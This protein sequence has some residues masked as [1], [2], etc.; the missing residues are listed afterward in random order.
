MKKRRF[1]QLVQTY[2]DLIYNYAFYFLHNRDEAEDVVQEVFIRVWK[3]LNIVLKANTKAW[4]LKTTK[5]LCLDQLRKRKLWDHSISSNSD[6]NERWDNLIPNENNL[7]HEI[8]QQDI[9]QVFLRFLSK[10]PE[11]IRE[12]LILREVMDYGVVHT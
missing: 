12:M 4:I 7:E 9:Q 1:K 5:N 8:E 6:Q 3:N 2:K 11:K 10:L